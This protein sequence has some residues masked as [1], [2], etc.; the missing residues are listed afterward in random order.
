M[1]KKKKYLDKGKEELVLFKFKK[2]D[3]LKEENASN[4]DLENF[5]EVNEQEILFFPFSCFEIIKKKR[6]NI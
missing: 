3:K 6:K 4:S 5:A 2:G 1:L